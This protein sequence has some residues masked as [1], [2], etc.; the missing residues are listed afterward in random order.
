MNE[1]FCPACHK[2]LILGEWPFCPHGRPMYS[3]IG[4]EC[5]VIQENGFAHPTRFTSKQALKKALDAKGLEMKVR[6]VPIPGTDKSPYTSDWARGTVDL[7]AAAAL[8]DPARRT[9]GP[10]THHD[11]TGPSVPITWTIRGIE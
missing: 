2:E 11:V 10:V 1:T 5:D 3:A 8:V 6:H 9:Q 4:D 7:D